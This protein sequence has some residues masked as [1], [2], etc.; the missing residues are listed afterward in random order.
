MKK[1]IA[2]AGT[3]L[4]GASVLA[5]CGTPLAEPFEPDPADKAAELASLACSYYVEEK[6]GPAIN[7]AAYAA[8]LDDR[9]IPLSEGMSEVWG[10]TE[11]LNYLTTADLDLGSS[12]GAALAADVM[13]RQA[14][15]TVA[16]GRIQSNCFVADVLLEELDE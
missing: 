4:L 16:D 5:G 9:W 7:R 1:K 10:N 15:A 12:Q 14:S 2:V 6:L 8:Y 13:S 3:V 11:M